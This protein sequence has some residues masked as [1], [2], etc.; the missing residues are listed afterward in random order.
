M[1][2]LAERL[3]ERIKST[4]VEDISV[5]SVESPVIDQPQDLITRIRNRIQQ[6][7]V[8][9][10]TPT[11]EPVVTEITPQERERRRDELEAATR[12]G[13][14]DF[15]K[16]LISNAGTELKDLGVAL[17]S[18]VRHPLQ[19]GKSIISA[20][21]KLTAKER[22]QFI[23]SFVTELAKDAGKTIGFDASR[24]T[25]G[26]VR[27]P[28]GAASGILSGFDVDT[29]IDRWQN[30]PISALGDATLI[31]GIGKKIAS[32]TGKVVASSA[33]KKAVR[34]AIERNADNLDQMG[35]DITDR[36]RVRAVSG[37]FET[38]FEKLLKHS[39]VIKG[40]RATK[41]PPMT[42]KILDS[43]DWFRRRSVELSDDLIK[44][45][46]SENVK[47][48][49]EISDAKN[50]VVSPVNLSLRV[51]KNFTGK[52][53]GDLDVRSVALKFIDPE[54]KDFIPFIGKKKVDVFTKEINKRIASGPLN[55]GTVK[56]IMDDIDDSINWLNPKSSDE[57]LKALRSAIRQELG[58]TLPSYDAAA[59]RV[60]DRL[61]TLGFI[62]NKI[63]GPKK[64][65][66]YKD[67]L[68]KEILK[69]EDFTEEVIG[70]L[71]S[72]AKQAR[73]SEAAKALGTLDALS[74][75]RA[76]NEFHRQ[77]Q[78][79][80]SNFLS[81]PVAPGLRTSL[82]IIGPIAEVGRQAITRARLS[83]TTQAVG[84]VVSPVAGAVRRGVT[85]P[86]R[87]PGAT[88]IAE[89]LRTSLEDTPR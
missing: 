1:A 88:S 41:M 56:K 24:I 64:I 76:W 62:E 19:S 21:N 52:R 30:Q 58:A 38:K 2:T 40:D 29:L 25:P 79:F 32:K 28:G 14:L 48:T 74:G 53:L 5:P 66:G 12:P 20:A 35:R 17:A 72:L 49:K 22:R 4:S 67:R 31:A 42:N 87:R 18:I 13:V 60:H 70:T 75:W 89:S 85:A 45:K 37:E 16:D 81:V 77:N 80:V 78:G 34:S 55:V 39:K 51:L 33:D 57:G 7:G 84:G 46:K 69:S 47:L 8:P 83:P 6:P 54:S 65:K 10:P 23:G 15:S 59:S 73:S 43:P 63:S 36:A 68:A 82:P 61:T 26:E 3:R 86:I 71:D 9:T 27:G 44:L 11:P 50:V